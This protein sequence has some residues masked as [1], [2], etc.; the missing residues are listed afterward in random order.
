LG[1][2]CSNHFAPSFPPSE[3]FVSFHVWSARPFPFTSS[4][5]RTSDR[6]PRSRTPLFFTCPWH[7][8]RKVELKPFANGAISPRFLSGLPEI[9]WP[10]LSPPH[11]S[12][13]WIRRSSFLFFFTPALP[14]L[15]L[16]TYFG[17]G[18]SSSTVFF[19]SVLV[20]LR[21]PF[22]TSFVS[23]ALFVGSHL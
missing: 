11:R 17:S 18:C 12:F 3:F 13:P 9:L 23:G 22:F 1:P 2:F 15:V 14:S 21:F 20:L 19:N 4:L 5:S 8:F 7:P 16:Q 6:F 10:S